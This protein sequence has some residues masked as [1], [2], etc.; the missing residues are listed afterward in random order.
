MVLFQSKYLN[1]KNISTGAGDED[2]EIQEP[3]GSALFCLRASAR[4]HPR[5]RPVPHLL[6]RD[7]E[8]WRDPGH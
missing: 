7:G 2:A 8:R 1:G 5:F 3:G 6:P 4:V